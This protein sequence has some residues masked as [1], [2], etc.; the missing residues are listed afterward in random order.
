MDDNDNTNKTLLH[1]RAV[2]DD[3]DHLR[4][5]VSGTTMQI[6]RMTRPSAPSQIEQIRNDSG[7]AIDVGTLHCRL[8]AEG[9]LPQACMGIMLVLVSAGTSFCRAPLADGMLVTIPGGLPMEF[10]IAPGFSYVGT[11]VPLTSWFAAQLFETGFLSDDRQNVVRRLSDERL[12]AARARFEG[13]TRELRRAAADPSLSGGSAALIQDHVV[14][15]ASDV[16]DIAGESPSRYSGNLQ[17]VA[18]RA[19]DWIHA[20]IDGVIRIADLC[21]AVGANR[22]KLE[23]AFRSVHDMSPQEY[24]QAL[25]LN[26]I[27]RAL[28]SGDTRGQSVTDVALRYGI[29]HFGRLSANYRALFDELPRD[30]LAQAR[31]QNREKRSRP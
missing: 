2:I 13:V 26:L 24:I 27:H 31:T 18:G 3:P 10:N 9:A 20:H 12:S 14:G 19:R 25:R 7:W 30:T 1:L 4:A 22:R 29:N 15:L 6:N 5:A 17:R 16:A 11:Q 21:S 8:H 23:Y 28:A